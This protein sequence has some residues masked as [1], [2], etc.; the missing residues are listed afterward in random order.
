MTPLPPL[1]PDETILWEGRPDTGLRFGIETVATGIFAG[2]LV[3]A[4]LGLATVINRSAPGMFWQIFA[5]GLAAGVLIVL[6]YPLLDRFYRSRTRYVL[7][8]KRGFV[9]GPGKGIK[10]PGDTAG[11]PIPTPDRV[12]YDPGPPGSVY[13]ARRPTTRKS[14]VRKSGRDVGF[15]RIA[16]ADKVYKIL[17]KLAEQQEAS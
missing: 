7:T 3:L 9:F 16:D 12:T 13:F 8:N 11:F 10:V 6:A 17:R 2:A 14:N 5:P 4:C 15:A 1:A